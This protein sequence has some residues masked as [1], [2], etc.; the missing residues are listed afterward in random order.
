LDKAL[1]DLE[2]ASAEFC[3]GSKKRSIINVV[4]FAAQYVG[5]LWEAD[6]DAW[7]REEPERGAGGDDDDEP[8]P[9]NAIIPYSL[10]HS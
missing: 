9:G 6:E 4:S 5:K 8:E 3:F 1:R 7:D 10:F 2:D